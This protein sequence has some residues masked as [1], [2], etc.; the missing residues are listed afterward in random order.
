MSL[1][2]DNNVFSTR[3]LPPGSVRLF[4]AFRAQLVLTGIITSLRFLFAEIGVNE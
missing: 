4:F 1:L 3:V 2:A